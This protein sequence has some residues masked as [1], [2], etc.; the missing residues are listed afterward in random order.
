MYN[1]NRHFDGDINT[2]LVNYRYD[3][4]D[5]GT[6]GLSSNPNFEFDYINSWTPTQTWLGQQQEMVIYCDYMDS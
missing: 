3:T 2:S 6:R 1:V 4:V 5:Q